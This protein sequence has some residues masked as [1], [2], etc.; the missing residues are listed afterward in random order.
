MHTL[1][2][3]LTVSSTTLEAS[4]DSFAVSIQENTP[5]VRRELEALIAEQAALRLFQLG[6]SEK[7]SNC[8]HDA[9]RLLNNDIS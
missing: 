5:L 3:T 8:R 6:G 4:V 1:F 7:H 2:V 9:D